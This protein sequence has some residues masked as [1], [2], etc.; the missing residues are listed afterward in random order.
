MLPVTSAITIAGNKKFIA[1]KLIYFGK[2]LVL[3]ILL[4]QT[5][6]LGRLLNQG[7]ANLE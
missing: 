6:L 3:T 7:N 1:I 5:V 2:F 4:T